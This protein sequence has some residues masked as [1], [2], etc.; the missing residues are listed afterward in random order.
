MGSISETYRFAPVA[1]KEFWTNRV[2]SHTFRQ[3]VRIG[4]K[5]VISAT[6]IWWLL[7]GIELSQIAEPLARISLLGLAFGIVLQLLAT[8]IGAWRWQLVIAE[9][10]RT[11]MISSVIV[12]IER[13]HALRY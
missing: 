12:S 11:R 4:I 10:G 9:W 7:S 6:L 13:R 5:G 2:N 8:F 1:A 3:M